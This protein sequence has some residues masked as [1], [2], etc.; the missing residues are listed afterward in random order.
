MAKKYQMSGADISLV[1]SLK[2]IMSEWKSCYAIDS[3]TESTFKWME[4][5][6]ECKQAGKSTATVPNTVKANVEV[7]PTKQEQF[8]ENHLVSELGGSMKQAVQG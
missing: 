8:L 3:H 1:S 5:Y 7:L 4:S 6:I 2:I